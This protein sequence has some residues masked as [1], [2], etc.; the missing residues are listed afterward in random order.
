MFDMRELDGSERRVHDHSY[1][2]RIVQLSRRATLI[3]NSEFSRSRLIEAGVPADRI[4]LHYL[5][6]QLQ[7]KPEPMSS[8]VQRPVILYVG[9]FVDCKGPDLTIEAFNLLRKVGTDAQLVMIGDGP[10]RE[11]CLALA[12]DSPFATDIELPGVEPHE[13]VS[14]RLKTAAV[15]SMHSMK[16]KVSGQEEA[17]GVA[18][19]DAMAAGLPVV[20]GKS[21]GIPE[22]VVH[23]KT[24]LLFEPGDVSGHAEYLKLL[25]DDQELACTMGSNGWERVNALFTQDQ[26]DA[27]LRAILNNV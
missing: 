25:L 26:S 2:E 21:G 5:G 24:G 13:A 7:S 19:L 3:A 22:I 1:R 20:T 14:R 16:G 4:V 15:F 9:R 18:F 27:S 17:F 6:V 8:R 23:E 10:E 11:R 12:K